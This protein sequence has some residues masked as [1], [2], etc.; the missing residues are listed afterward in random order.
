MLFKL[1]YFNTRCIYKLLYN[2]CIYDLFKYFA[3]KNSNISYEIFYKKQCCEI[4]MNE[5]R[6]L[7][8]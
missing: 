1:I 7:L 4:R 3:I 8:K 2:I 6:F 5:M